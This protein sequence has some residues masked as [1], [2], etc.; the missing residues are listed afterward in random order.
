[1]MCTSRHEY[2]TCFLT[3]ISVSEIH[4]T[5]TRCMI[6]Y[7]KAADNN[8]FTIYASEGAEIW[9]PYQMPRFSLFLSSISVIKKPLTSCGL[10]LSVKRGKWIWP[11]STCPALK[12][13]FILPPCS[14]GHATLQLHSAKWTNWRA[15]YFYTRVEGIYFNRCHPKPGK[16]TL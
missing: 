6:G 12:S 11:E 1:M 7:L 9:K 4:V 16:P 3:V 10:H 13:H 8:F 15:A 2:F 5:D 14:E